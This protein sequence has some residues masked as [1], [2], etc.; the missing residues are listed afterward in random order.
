MES[1]TIQPKESQEPN[2]LDPRLLS[3]RLPSAPTVGRSKFCGFRDVADLVDK[4][5]S[6]SLLG[7]LFRLA[8]SGHP[9]AIEGTSVFRE[10]RAGLT[11]FATMAYII[12]VNASIL[13][14][15]GGTCDCSLANRLQ[16]DT[17]PG[18]VDCKEVEV[19]RDLITAT[20]ALAGIASLFFGLLTNLPVALAPG[21]G[22]NAY[23]AYQVVGSNGGGSI[24]YRTALTAVF[25]EGLIFMF[26]ALTG[27]RQWLVRLIPAT[28]KTATGVGIGFFLTEIGLSYSSGI[29]AITGGGMSTPL[30]LGGCPPDRIDAETGACD[31]GQMTNPTIWL[32]IF[33]GGIITAFLMAFRVKYALVIGIALVSIISWPRNTPVTYFPNT[34]EGDSRFAFFKQIVA[35]HPLA[36][37]LNQ[38]DWSLAATSTSHFI[39][40]L[41]TFLYVDIIDATATLYSMVRFCGVVNPKDGDFPRSTIAYCTDAAFISIGAL[42]GCSPVT[43]FIESGAGIAEGGRT[44]LTAVVTGLCFIISIFFAP[45][46]ASIPPWATGCTLILVGCM[47]IRQITQVNWRYIG[48]VLPSFVVM[49]FIPFSYSVA[50]G[51]I[52]GL[53]VYTTLNSLIGLVVFLTNNRIEPREY[54]LKEYWTWKGSGRAPWFVRAMRKDNHRASP[55]SGDSHDN[56]PSS[57]PD[58]EESQRGFNL[59]Q[60]CDNPSNKDDSATMADQSALQSHDEDFDYCHRSSPLRGIAR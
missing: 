42:F 27:M 28:I 51:L 50:Y 48:D 5:L 43:A 15:T 10:I 54:D 52:A 40:A 9:D 55:S 3:P 24:S 29:G 20:A 8:G 60:S 6:T 53:F 1:P 25:F 41:F 2:M 19:R 47:M 30:A 32:A 17:I 22:L 31:G 39:L 4:W 36:N 45:I 46:F 57:S 33:C 26:L 16:C 38:L 35:W 44:G 37:T 13:S 7:R 58:E 49:T 12:A 23:F 11:T 56:T 18:Y 21:M 14:Q 34:P 59:Q